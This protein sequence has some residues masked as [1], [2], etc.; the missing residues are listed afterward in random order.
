[1]GRF[2][3]EINSQVKEELLDIIIA[4]NVIFIKNILAK[5]GGCMLN[6]NVLKLNILWLCLLVLAGLAVAQQDKALEG[7]PPDA[8]VQKIHV[9]AQKYKFIPEEIRIKKNT[10]VIL[11]I[12][13]L[14]TAHGFK[15]KSF[16]IEVEI[17]AHGKVT[18]EFYAR[19]TG[20]YPFSC[21]VLCGWLHFW[22]DGKIIV[23]PN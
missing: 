21:S 17:P 12:E 23:E 16:G 18:V 11:E 9:T 7:M 5:T 15:L 20:T 6:H 10:Q 2:M 14:D 8:P 4:L 1:M 22:M 13:S 19:E 3:I